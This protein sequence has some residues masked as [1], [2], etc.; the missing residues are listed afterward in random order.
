MLGEKPAGAEAQE[1]IGR[2]AEL[3]TPTAATDRCSDQSPEGGAAQPGAAEATRWQ[4]NAGNDKR[5]RRVDEARRLG[6]GANPW[7]ANPGRGC[8][9]KQAHEVRGGGN[10]RGREKRR[11]RNEGRTWESCR[12]WTPRADVAMG[13]FGTPRE[14]LA[15]YGR[16]AGLQ[17]GALCRGGEAHERMNPG[18]QENGG[19]R[20]GN[21]TRPAGNSEVMVGAGN[22]IG[23]LLRRSQYSEEQPTS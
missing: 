21:T 5:A 3:N 23:P 11:G 15:A 18:S 10:R 16:R 4:G 2:S 9:M 6:S 17:Q 7:R 20:R 12:T 13:T 19:R 8:G 22:P 1:G 14:V